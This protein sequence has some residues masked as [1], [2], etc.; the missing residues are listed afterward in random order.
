MNEQAV[1]LVDRIN[2]WWYV[3]A[4][5]LPIVG[6]VAGIVFMAKS[7]IGPSLALFMTSY[8]AGRSEMWLA[9]ATTVRPSNPWAVLRNPR[10]HGGFD[11]S[12]GPIRT[13]ITAW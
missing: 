7:K 6:A 11:R 10:A 8:V 9:R 13:A 3:T 4:F 1:V 5:V 12:G 2:P